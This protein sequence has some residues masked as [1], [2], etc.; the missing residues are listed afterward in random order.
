MILCNN[1]AC[2]FCVMYN[3]RSTCSRSCVNL[4]IDMEKGTVVCHDCTKKEEGEI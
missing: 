1:T 4:E 3:A 2:F